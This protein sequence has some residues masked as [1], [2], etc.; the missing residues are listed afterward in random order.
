M[1]D[2]ADIAREGTIQFVVSCK[3]GHDNP[4]SRLFCGECGT[5]IVPTVAIC[6]LGHINGKEQQFCGDC[7][8]PIRAPEGAGPDSAGGRWNVDPSGRHQY[9]YWSSGKWTENIADNGRFGIDPFDGGKAW[10]PET[11][12]GILAG[13]ATIVLVIGA[14]VGIAS[15]LSTSASSKSSQAST[16]APETAV[17]SPGLPPPPPSAEPIAGGVAVIGTPCLPNSSDGVTADGSVAHCETLRATGTTM[18]SLFAGDVPSPYPP[19]I[20]PRSMG[21]PAVAVCMAQTARTADQCAEYLSRPS[22]PG[23]GR[24]AG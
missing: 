14:T 22:D 6:V 5:P 16:S 4:E 3:N 15:Q 21:E 24:A 23:D 19:G 13:L 12:V 10:H 8:V 2:F 17:A 18:W 20:D 1:G 7:G 11:W 9:R